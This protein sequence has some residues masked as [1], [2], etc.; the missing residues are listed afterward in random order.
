M[1]RRQQGADCC[2]RFAALRSVTRNQPTAYAVGYMLSPLR[3][4]EFPAQPVKFMLS[5]SKLADY[6]MLDVSV[7][8]A[9]L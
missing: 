6:F 4:Y 9:K 2:L 5:A 1:K 7:L 3:G 8:A